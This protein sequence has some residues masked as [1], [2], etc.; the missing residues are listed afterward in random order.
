MI[1]EL[2]RFYSGTPLHLFGKFLLKKI[3]SLKIKIVGLKKK[4]GRLYENA[5]GLEI[6]RMTNPV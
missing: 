2:K 4:S 1:F 5:E 6:W 3:F